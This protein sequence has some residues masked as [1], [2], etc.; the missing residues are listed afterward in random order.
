MQKHGNDISI[1]YKLNAFTTNAMQHPQSR[2]RELIILCNIYILL[3]HYIIVHSVVHTWK[4]T[5][6]SFIFRLKKSHWFTDTL[7]I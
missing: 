4:E 2:K 3:S 1:V 7:G 6:I 5:L